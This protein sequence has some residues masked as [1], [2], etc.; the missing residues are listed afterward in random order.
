MS[1]SRNAAPRGHLHFA[2]AALQFFVE[3]D[4][5]MQCEHVAALLQHLD[6]DIRCARVEPPVVACDVPL[7]PLRK[8][9]RAP[10]DLQ[11]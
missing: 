4:Q 9:D 10:S 2:V 8:R 7:L 11:G 6:H 1:L 5:Q 3:Q